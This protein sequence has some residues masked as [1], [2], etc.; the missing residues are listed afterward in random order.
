MTEH[1]N[2]AG[3]RRRLGWTAFSTLSIAVGIGISA[4]GCSGAHGTTTAPVA[5][6]SSALAS[7]FPEPATVPPSPPLPSASVA[8][9]VSW[10]PATPP[11]TPTRA[12][13]A[14]PSP[15]AANPANAVI[16][17]CKQQ[18]VTQPTQFILACGDGTTSLTGL[19]WSN[20]GAAT[21]TATG[22]YETVVCT[23]NCAAGAERSYPATVSLTGL[24]GGMYA[25]MSISAPKSSPPNVSYSLGSAGPRIKQS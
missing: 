8:S 17:D 18:S 22:V 5:A 25:E 24:S 10:K 16:R 11:A 4:A 21:A 2:T 20:W 9:V 3:S 15:A 13:S 19:H 1:R 7:S 23:P 6:A 12:S 14:T